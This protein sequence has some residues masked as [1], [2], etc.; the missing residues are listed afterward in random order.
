MQTTTQI[1]YQE[2][3]LL[4]FWPSNVKELLF[5]VTEILY[6]K[7][8]LSILTGFLPAT[9]VPAKFTALCRLKTPFNDLIEIICKKEEEKIINEI[10]QKERDLLRSEKKRKWGK[11][12][13]RPF[14]GVIDGI[15][16]TFREKLELAKKVVE[17]LGTPEVSKKRTNRGRKPT[18]DLKKTIPAVLAKGDLSFES[19]SDELKN[20]NYDATLNGSGS[21]PGHT[22]LH[23]LFKD[24]SE[25]YYK[26][27]LKMLDDMIVELYS[28]FKENM[29]VFVG[30]N[31]ALACETLIKRK[32]AMELKLVR[33]IQPFFSLSRIHTNSIRYIGKSTN[34]IGD[35]VPYIP[36]NSILILDSE[37]DVDDNYWAGI[38]NNIEVQIKQKNTGRIRLP[39]R[40]KGKQIFDRKKYNKRKLGERPFGN[41]E[42]R[43]VK[44]YYRSEKTRLKGCLLIGIE[45]DLISWYKN[46]AWCD[47]FVEL[48]I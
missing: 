37:F 3:N 36:E 1:L 42:K 4:N 8:T 39:G 23:D 35:A 27:A 10:L 19:V 38:N 2:P 17:R 32:I 44:C 34:K 24:I 22:Y 12:T 21:S 31:S 6:Q 18:Y 33:E 25:E 15:N 28:K 14:R 45:H 5:I 13:R 30:D 7:E 48:K 26:K 11:R 40:K 20:I 47:Q 46:K 9:L 43:K 29:N 41:I 16:P